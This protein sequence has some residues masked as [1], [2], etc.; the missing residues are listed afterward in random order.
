MSCRFCFL[1]L[2]KMRSIVARCFEDS[3]YADVGSYCEFSIERRGFSS[4][5]MKKIRSYVSKYVLM[6]F[7]DLIQSDA[8]L[9]HIQPVL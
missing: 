5:A 3:P 8:S 4:K 1:S 6:M 9:L 2:A 7:W